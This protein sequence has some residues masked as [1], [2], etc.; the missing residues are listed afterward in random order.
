[1]TLQVDGIPILVFL[2]ET[3]RESPNGIKKKNVMPVLQE[4]KAGSGSKL[5]YTSHELAIK[6]A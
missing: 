4:Q 2:Y 3:S 5:H 6:E 1:M